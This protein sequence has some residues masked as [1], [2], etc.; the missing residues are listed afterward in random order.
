MKDIN[1]YESFETDKYVRSLGSNNLIDDVEMKLLYLEEQVLRIVM[2]CILIS[3]V[4]IA[5]NYFMW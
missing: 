3:L 5:S 2:S 1:S 4:I